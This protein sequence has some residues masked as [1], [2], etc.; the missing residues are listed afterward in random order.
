MRI[1]TWMRFS[2]LLLCILLF[3]AGARAQQ[4]KATIGIR[5]GTYIPQDWEIQGMFQVNYTSTGSPTSAL[6]S[7]FGNGS[8]IMLHGT[9]F[10]S[11]WG[12]G[13][14]AGVVLMKDRQI[15]MIFDPGIRNMYENNL[16]I[17][18]ITVS[19]L[20]RL[21]ESGRKFQPYAGVGAGI[22]IG[23][24][25]L[26]HFPEGA[27]RTWL[28]GSSNPVEFHFLM[29]ADFPV[30]YNLLLSGQ[31]KYA[32]TQSD[33]KLTNQDNGEV[34]EMRGLNVGGVELGFGLSYQF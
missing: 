12:V 25:E 11:D 27:Q 30:Y 33:W 16:T 26:K 4:K 14:E 24:M 2:S 15:D 32:V 20:H 23:E 31:I 19:L 6:V 21:G 9:Y 10:P 13:L 7:G 1:R 8:I 5:F 28:K 18:P 34:N 29:G 3:T 17:F 22:Y